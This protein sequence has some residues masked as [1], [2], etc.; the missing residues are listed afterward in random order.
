MAKAIIEVQIL[1][2]FLH[3]KDSQS[4]EKRAGHFA[5][6][7]FT[8]GIGLPRNSQPDSQG[9][10]AGGRGAVAAQAGGRTQDQRAAG[11]GGVATS[12]A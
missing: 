11:H 10:T 7:E 5:A 1:K 2:I 9:R 12:G 8:R 6:G 4:S 3:P